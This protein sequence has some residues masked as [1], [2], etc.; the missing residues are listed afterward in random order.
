MPY[1][2]I[3]TVICTGVCV[4][5]HS[6]HSDAKQLKNILYIAALSHS[7]ASLWFTSLRFGLGF[8]FCF[9]SCCC[10]CFVLSVFVGFLVSVSFWP[11]PVIL[12]MML[13]AVAETALWQ[14]RIVYY[15]STLAPHTVATAICNWVDASTGSAAARA[16]LVAT[17]WKFGCGSFIFIL[18]FTSSKLNQF[19]IAQ[20]TTTAMRLFAAIILAVK[21]S[22]L[23]SVKYFI[24]SR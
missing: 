16:L 15:Y 24:S 12:P 5:L 18:V 2:A 20:L 7:F 14:S 21:P 3:R 6:A 10:C 22:Q 23:W 4:Y 11:V 19:S 13:A 8:C 17:R 9:C 1:R